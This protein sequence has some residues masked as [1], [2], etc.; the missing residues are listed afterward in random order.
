MGRQRVSEL[1]KAWPRRKEAE[2]TEALRV[3]FY[4]ELK[5]IHG[6]HAE[7]RDVMGCIA[8]WERTVGET[9]RRTH[10]INSQ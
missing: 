1:W 9:E 2:Q 7:Y 5:S 8:K 10:Q 4:A 6:I 3:L